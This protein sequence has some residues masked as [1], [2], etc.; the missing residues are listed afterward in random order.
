MFGLKGFGGGCLYPFTGEGFD[1]G[2]AGAGLV[3]CFAGAVIDGGV[4]PL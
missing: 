3:G 1:G 4:Y 2:L